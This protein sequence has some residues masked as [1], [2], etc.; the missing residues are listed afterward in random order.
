MTVKF[1]VPDY[2]IAI[3]KAAISTI[4]KVGIAVENQA[5]KTAPV[6]DGFYR[7]N[8]KYDAGNREVVAHANY[9]AA[10]EYGVAARILKARNAKALR[11]TKG[12]NTVFAKSVKLPARPP[13]PVMRNAARYASKRSSSIFFEELRHV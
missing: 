11:F 2:S 6:K 4:N 1:N 5:K 8:I 7:A 13:N 12:G 9:S 10:I 3:T